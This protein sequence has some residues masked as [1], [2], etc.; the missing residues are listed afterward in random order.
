LGVPWQCFLSIGGTE[1]WRILF[2]WCGIKLY[3]YPVLLYLGALIGVIAGTYRATLH[4]PNPARVYAAILLL[5]PMALV[6]ARL[7]FIIS[8][9]PIYRLEPRRIWR[10]SEGGVSFACAAGDAP[11]HQ[12][13]SSPSLGGLHRLRLSIA[14]RF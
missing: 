6:G 8:H 12:E 13:V 3:S 7:L 5:F 9:W 10:Q 4:S 11:K 14:K 1:V 2:E